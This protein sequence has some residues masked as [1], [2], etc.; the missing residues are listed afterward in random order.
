MYSLLKKHIS[1]PSSDSVIGLEFKH[2]SKE[3]MVSK[4]E[5]VWGSN[6]C[7]FM[8]LQC[9]SKNKEIYKCIAKIKPNIYSKSKM[10]AWVLTI[11]RKI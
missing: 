8:D 5:R 6:L 7:Y 10:D 2:K 9:T 4:I 3:F 1:N 11:Q